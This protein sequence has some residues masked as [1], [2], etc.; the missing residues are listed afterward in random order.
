M[1]GEIYYKIH[2]YRRERDIYSEKRWWAYLSKYETRCLNDLF[3][4]GELK[5][6]FDDLL[7]IPGLWGRIRISTLN[8]IISIR[9]DEVS[10]SSA[11]IDSLLTIETGSSSLSLT[12]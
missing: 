7:G 6:A 10:L 8:K 11:S 1:A 12:H 4:Y 3:Y 9:Y 5:A 2:K